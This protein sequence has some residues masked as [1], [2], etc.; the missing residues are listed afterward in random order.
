MRGKM[1]SKLGTKP[2]F[3]GQK[4]NP[5]GCFY[6]YS[7]VL[8]RDPFGNGLMY[9]VNHGFSILKFNYQSKVF[10]KPKR[11]VLRSIPT[12]AWRRKEVKRMEKVCLK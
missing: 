6:P 10:P 1:K 9:C 12:V 3:K 11:T 2:I 5:C 7:T 4:S 8:G